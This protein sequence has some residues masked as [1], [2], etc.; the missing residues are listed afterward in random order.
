MGQKIKRALPKLLINIIIPA[1]LYYLLTRHTKLS[2]IEVLIISGIPSTIFTIYNFIF[3]RRADFMGIIPIFGFIIGIISEVVA[4]STNNE[5]LFLLKKALFTC[6][7]ALLHFITLIPIKIKSFEMRPLQ[8]YIAKSSGF[9]LRGLTEDEPIP[10][11]WERYWKSYH[12]FRQMFYVLTAIWGFGILID[13][14][15]HV[16]IVYSTP[17]NEAVIINDIV[18]YSWLGFL[19]LTT[20]FYIKFVVRVR[21]KK[22]I[23]ERRK[24]LLL[25]LLM[26]VKNYIKVYATCLLQI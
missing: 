12:L 3:N 11:R 20:I 8:F 18:L 25:M 2:H 9:E 6:A 13:V 22:L 24:L 26:L 1:L 21:A 14:V 7:F 10:E 15:L 19:T 17:F 5:Q 23:E 16:I 4:Y